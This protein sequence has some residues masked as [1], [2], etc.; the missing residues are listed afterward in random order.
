MFTHNGEE[1]ETTWILKTRKQL[2]N[3]QNTNS[4]ILNNIK[5]IFKTFMAVTYEK[6]STA[7]PSAITHKS[8]SILVWIQLKP[9]TYNT[10]V[11][12]AEG[13]M[14]TSP[15]ATMDQTKMRCHPVG[16]QASKASREELLSKCHKPTTYVTAHCGHRNVSV[17]RIL[18]FITVVGYTVGPDSSGPRGASAVTPSPDRASQ[19]TWAGD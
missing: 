5:F 7:I 2:G 8:I 15:E 18:H 9:L 4:V 16:E 6:G 10:K 3:L 1:L 17:L 13:C 19:G 14:T 12:W 11:C